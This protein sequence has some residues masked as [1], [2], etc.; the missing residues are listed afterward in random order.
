MRGVP[1]LADLAAVLATSVCT[2]P[3]SSVEIGDVLEA[4]TWARSQVDDGA[5]HGTTEA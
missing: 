3:S 1:E 4:L 2:K 5:T